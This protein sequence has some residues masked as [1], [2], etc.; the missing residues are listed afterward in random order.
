MYIYFHIHS[1]SSLQIHVGVLMYMC[2]NFGIILGTLMLRPSV[3][4]AGLD[5]NG[6]DDTSTKSSDHGTWT[7]SFFPVEIVN[8]LISLRNVVKNNLV[9][10]IR[11]PPPL[12][13]DCFILLSDSGVKFGDIATRVYESWWTLQRY[14]L[15]KDSMTIATPNERWRFVTG[16][17]KWDLC[18]LCLLLSRW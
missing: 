7:C 6:W 4:R 8:I 12:F 13:W 3:L 11:W 15:V 16:N 17:N 10:I 18:R 14:T 1:R 2:V 9:S 5:G